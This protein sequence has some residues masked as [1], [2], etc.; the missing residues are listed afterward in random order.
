MDNLLYQ[1]R[2]NSKFRQLDIVRHAEE[3]GGFCRQ[4]HTK[5]KG[6]TSILSTSH[7]IVCATCYLRSQRVVARFQNCFTVLSTPAVRPLGRVFSRLSTLWLCGHIAYSFGRVR[8]CLGQAMPRCCAVRGESALHSF[9]EVW[10]I[11]ASLGEQ[12]VGR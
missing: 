7:N 2:S 11:R 3:V 6:N 9:G 4:K 1:Q 5:P 10:I 12:A 8:H